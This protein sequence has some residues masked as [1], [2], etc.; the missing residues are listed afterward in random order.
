MAARTIPK[1]N[2]FVKSAMKEFVASS[3]TTRIDPQWEDDQHKKKVLS[4]NH[5]SKH[6][7]G[8]SHSHHDHIISVVDE[9]DRNHSGNPNGDWNNWRNN[10]VGND[11]SGNYY[12]NRDNQWSEGVH[13]APDIIAAA[14]NER[15][16]VKLR[17]Q[18][19]SNQ[20]RV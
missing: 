14:K 7:L 8:H 1:I 4:Q 13:I 9:D 2:T 20:D 17:D 18:I 3:E 15:Y 11:R 5:S 16:L 10:D 19:K 6:Q 12:Y